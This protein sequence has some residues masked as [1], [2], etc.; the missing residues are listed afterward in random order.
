MTRNKN[1]MGKKIEASVPFV[2][3]GVPEKKTTRRSR[4]KFVRRDGR[5]VGIQAHPKNLRCS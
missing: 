4:G 3:R 1:A 2:I 5:G